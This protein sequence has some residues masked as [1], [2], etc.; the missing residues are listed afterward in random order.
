MELTIHALTKWYGE[1]LALDHV[2]TS[3][4]EGVYGLLGP[5]GAGKSTLMNLLVGNLLP[6][7]GIIQVDGRNV[8]DMGQE[9]R[10]LLGYMPQQQIFYPYFTARR[11]LEYMSVLKGMDG[12][13]A[14]DDISELLMRVELTDLAGQKIRTFSGGMKQ[15]LLLAQALLGDPKILILDEPTAGL[16]PRQR[17]LVRQLI[18]EAAGDKII[19]IATHVISDVESLAKELILL[20]NGKIVCKGNKERL[21]QDMQV[22]RNPCSFGTDAVRQEKTLEDV[23]M[24]Y[25]GEKAGQED[26]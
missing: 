21:I 22:S 17:I 7:D 20:K 3:L 4:T 12:K 11:F 18:S 25:F 16:D 9:Y 13:Q 24:H 5:N 23:Y 19:L 8:I 26:G 14:A 1:K 10:A 6:S 15:R 2:S